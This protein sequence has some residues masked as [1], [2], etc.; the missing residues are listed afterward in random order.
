VAFFVLIF[1]ISKQKHKDIYDV[2]MQISYLLIP[3][4][5]YKDCS[6]RAGTIKLPNTP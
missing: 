5:L 3:T 4:G 1:I 2:A 6:S